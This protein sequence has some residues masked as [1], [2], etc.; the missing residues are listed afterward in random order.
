[1]KKLLIVF[2]GLLAWVVAQSHEFWLQPKKFKYKVGEEM[3]IDFLVGENFEGEPWDLKKNK[4]E[5]LELHHLAKVTDLRTQVKREEKDK[6]KVKF[7]EAGT[8]L[9]S[10]QSDN[11]FIELDAQKFND[12]L[13]EDGLDEILDIRTKTKTMDKPSKEFYSRYVKV[14]VQVGDK[15]DDT[16]KKKTNLR[17][18][19]IPQQN[20]CQLKSGDYL[21]CILLFDGK[22]MPHQMVKIWNK[23][24]NNSVLQNAFTEND[25]TVKFPISSKGPWMLSTVKMKASEKPGADWQ[26]FWGSLVFGVE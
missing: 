17:L 11:A 22:P 25:G 13:Q 24:G 23:I 5:K 8:Y 10:M 26:S 20:P 1:M 18:E 2:T 19:I 9:L 16:F 12:Y 7:L 15:A 21:T 4:I 3:K 14:F 6:L